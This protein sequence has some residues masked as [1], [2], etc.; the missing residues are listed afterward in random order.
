MSDLMSLLQQSLGKEELS[1]LSQSIGADE[2]TTKSAIGAALPALIGGLG[3]Q[4]STPEGASGLLSALNKEGDGLTLDDLKG[5]LSSSG[6]E[7]ESDILPKV[8]G[9]RQERVQQG[10]S[11]ASGLDL[12]SVKKLLATLGPMVMGALAKHKKSSGMDAGKLTEFL[13]KEKASVDQQAGGAIGKMLDQ[14]DDGDFDLSD[15][16]NLAMGQLFGKK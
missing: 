1:A 6:T 3:R 10:V 2:E 11:K 4:G 15:V 9:D 7:S 16:A 12:N 5:Y 8:L 14:D 13:G